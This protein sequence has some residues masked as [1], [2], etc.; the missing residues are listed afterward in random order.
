MCQV[1]LR[2]YNNYK[3]FNSVLFI[4]NASIVFWPDISMLGSMS[5]LKTKKN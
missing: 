4:L 2:T 5:V 1:S 3:V